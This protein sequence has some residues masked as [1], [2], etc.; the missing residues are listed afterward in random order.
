MF[1]SI[2]TIGSQRWLTIVVI[3]VEVARR[4]CRPWIA[5]RLLPFFSDSA[6]SSISSTATAKAA[7]GGRERGGH[8]AYGVSSGHRRTT[9]SRSRRIARLALKSPVVDAY[10]IPRAANE[11][12]SP[13]LRFINLHGCPA[14]YVMRARARAKQRDHCTV[15]T[16]N[17]WFI[18]ETGINPD[19]SRI[20]R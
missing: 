5:A 4:S 13:S 1:L 2:S 3:D 20:T 14:R 9:A 8:G 12:D 10:V 17:G 7:A 18:R 19:L 11:T 15:T 6:K 16:Y